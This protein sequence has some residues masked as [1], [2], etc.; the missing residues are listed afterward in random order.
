M[1]RRAEVIGAMVISHTNHHLRKV[2][3]SHFEAGGG[4]SVA[5]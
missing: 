2:Q 3:D 4:G 1:K 5:N